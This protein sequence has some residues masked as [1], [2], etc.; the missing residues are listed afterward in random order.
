M[1]Y[2]H[3][4]YFLFKKNKQTI[5]DWFEIMYRTTKFLS[6]GEINKPFPAAPIW[7]AIC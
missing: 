4:F 7:L 5:W 1:K 3:S 6:T 2:N